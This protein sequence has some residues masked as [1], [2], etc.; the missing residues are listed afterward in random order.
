MTLEEMVLLIWDQT[1]P[2]GVISEV[3]ESDYYPQAI[4]DQIISM[5]SIGWKH[6]VNVMDALRPY[7]LETHAQDMIVSVDLLILLEA[8]QVNQEHQKLVNG[9]IMKLNNLHQMLLSPMEQLHLLIA[10]WKDVNQA[11]PENSLHFHLV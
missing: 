7:H 3:Q 11:Q 2:I 5:P 9:S 8:N 6:L 10:N 4:L 1:A